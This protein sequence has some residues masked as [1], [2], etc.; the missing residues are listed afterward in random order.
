MAR[1]NFAR[2]ESAAH[3]AREYERARKLGITQKEFA[4]AT[5]ISSD[6]YLRKILKGE[7]S[8]RIIEQRSMTGG[9]FNIRST[10]KMPDG[11]EVVVSRNLRIPSGT[12]RLDIFK[13]KVQKAIRTEVGKTPVR[14]TESPLFKQARRRFRFNLKGTKFIP[15]R[16]VKSMPTVIDVTKPRSSRAA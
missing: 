12:S 8:G 7:R 10:A 5:G 2:S 11:T 6:R 4:K 9:V 13:P 1:S 15:D 3:V 14:D 16:E